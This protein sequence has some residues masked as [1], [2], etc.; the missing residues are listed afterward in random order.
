M[1]KCDKVYKAL[2]MVID[3]VNLSK[4]DIK[5]KQ[6]FTLNDISSTVKDLT[7]T[8]SLDYSNNWLGNVLYFETYNG[9]IYQI[10]YD[11]RVDKVTCIKGSF[12]DRPKKIS[13]KLFF[14]KLEEYINGFLK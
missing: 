2:N 9:V 11:N 8:D 13:Q 7:Y 6:G 4:H 3:N 14:E 1:K 5:V 10:T 12:F